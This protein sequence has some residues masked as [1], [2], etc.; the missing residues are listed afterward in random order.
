MPFIVEIGQQS[1]DSNAY[2]STTFV[3]DY[4]LARGRT[5]WSNEPTSLKEAAII[6]ATDYIEQRFG[7]RFR[8]YK[9]SKIQ[10]LEWPRNN[11]SDNDSWFFM[12][13]HDIPP[14]LKKACAE[15]ALIALRVGELLP[16]P[17]SPVNQQSLTANSSQTIL[18][19]GVVI[20]KREKVGPIEEETKYQSSV[21]SQKIGGVLPS[22]SS[23]VSSFFIPE[24]PLADL[25]MEELLT[26]PYSRSFERA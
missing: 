8:G 17:P 7:K 26:N 11:A 10:G 5:D 4:Q 18:P 15:Y 21:E 14:Q 19:T 16:N 13:E 22:K 6:R 3:D 9:R 2:V 24:Y 1:P 23:L 12:G 20:N 25:W